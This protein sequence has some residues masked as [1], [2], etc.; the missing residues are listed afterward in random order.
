MLLILLLEYDSNSFE[1]L[2]KCSQI[3]ILLF[4]RKVTDN[5]KLIMI[6]IEQ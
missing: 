5:I 3:L 2:M 6:F 4:N 1:K